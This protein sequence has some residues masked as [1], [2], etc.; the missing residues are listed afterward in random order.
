MTDGNTQIEE[1]TNRQWD[2]LVIGGGPAGAIAARQTAA[3]GLRTLLVDKQPFPRSKV[4]GACV[5]RRVLQ[6]LSR[7]GMDAAIAE[8]PSQPYASL[9]LACGTRQATLA[10]PPGKVIARRD[11]DHALVR[12]AIRAGACWLP[13]T[14]ATVEGVS[15]DRLTRRVE[16]THGKSQTTCSAITRLVLVADGLSHPSLH[17]RKREFPSVVSRGSRIGVGGIVAAAH[18]VRSDRSIH[19]NVT[20]HGYV[21]FVRLSDGTYNVAAALDAT[22]LKRHSTPADAMRVMLENTPLAS[23]DLSLT[24][25]KGTPRLTRRLL[26]P[27]SSRVLVLGDAAGYVEPFTGEGI[28]WAVTSGA[29][30]AHLATQGIT[31]WSA[32]LE[33]RWVE[34]L[35]QLLG[36]G[37][38][39]CQSLSRILRSPGWASFAIRC[40]SAFPKLASP[41]TFRAE[42]L[43]ASLDHVLTPHHRNV[44][45]SRATQKSAMINETCVKDGSE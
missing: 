32:A 4:C 5:N 17:R 22:F 11:F 1:T 41:I 21:G 13:E 3:A 19:I 27:A 33:N 9:A 12:E 31:D 8:L 10:L 25:W 36:G 37:Q 18:G 6:V 43:P 24:V 45:T 30:A 44:S 23:L 20:R 2:V 16:L 15:T 42:R 29:A 35:R 38:F 34:Q 28:A 14:A 7:L 39:V 26:R 40:V